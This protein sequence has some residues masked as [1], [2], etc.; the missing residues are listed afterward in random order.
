MDPLRLSALSLPIREDVH[1]GVNLNT[2][3]VGVRAT[4]ISD[5]SCQ[6]N[7]SDV[8]K[9]TT[10]ALAGNKGQDTTD[11]D[12]DSGGVDLSRQVE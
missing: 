5:S 1:R 10:R 7:I 6:N 9:K 3:A 8:E 2:R 4:V 11:G 12:L